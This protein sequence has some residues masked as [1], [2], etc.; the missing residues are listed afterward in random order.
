M[1][2]GGY[3][4]LV[5]CKTEHSKQRERGELSLWGGL[6][7]LLNQKLGKGWWNSFRPYK[8]WKQITYH[9]AV[10]LGG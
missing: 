5:R 8:N 7:F 6:G 2:A 4:C 9:E 10:D 3:V 1:L